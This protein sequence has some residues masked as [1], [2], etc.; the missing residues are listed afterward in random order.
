MRRD[1]W[2]QV[3]KQIFREKDIIL[4]K[5]RELEP[6]RNA[7][8]HVRELSQSQLQKLKLYSEDIVSCTEK[9]G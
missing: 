5:L 9:R 6:I 2:E 8:A 4:A 7:I 1:N 3:F